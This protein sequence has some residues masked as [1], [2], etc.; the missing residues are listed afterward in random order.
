MQRRGWGGSVSCIRYWWTENCFLRCRYW[1]SSFTIML[2]SHT[3]I[4][5]SRH[6]SLGAVAWP[7]VPL[8]LAVL[9]YPLQE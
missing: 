5:R 4:P 6:I 7:E 9:K 1:N 3:L 2:R 8:L